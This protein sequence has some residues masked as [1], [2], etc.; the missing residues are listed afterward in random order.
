MK[1]LI[2]FVALLFSLTIS[3]QEKKEQTVKNYT[4]V[5]VDNAWKDKKVTIFYHLHNKSDD[6]LIRFKDSDLYCRQKGTTL[7]GYT[8]SGKK[9]Q[10]LSF[11]Q[12]NGD[13]LHLQY[14]EEH[15]LYGIR[16]FFDDGT[17]LQLVQ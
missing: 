10:L 4:K 7:E 12:E 5:F 15:S 2:L 3:A 16:L 9:Y 14:F 13:T 6:I 11:E 1:K 17:V 8:S